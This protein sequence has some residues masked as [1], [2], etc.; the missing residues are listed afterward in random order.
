MAAYHWQTPSPGAALERV[1]AIPLE[2]GPDELLLEVLHCGLCHSDVSMID[3]AWSMSSYP[4]VPGHEAVG[5]VIAVGDG[6]DP[7][8]VGELR[9][10]GWFAGSCGHCEQCLAGR[11]NLCSKAES[12]IV[13]RPGAFASQV[14]AHQ[15]WAIPVPAGL[16]AADAGPLFCGGITVFAPLIDEAVSPT[17]RVAVIGVGGLG[18]LALQFSRAWGCEVTAITSSPAKAEEAKRLGAH[19]V[20]AS[21]DLPSQAGRFDL[22]INTVNQPLDWAAVVAAL[23]PLGRLHLLGAVLEPIPIHA[24]DLIMTRR[25]ITGSPTSSPASLRK[26]VEFCARHGILPMVEHLPMAEVNEA[27]HRLRQGDVRFRFVLDGHA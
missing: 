3:N 2:P 27:I 21:A 23:A 17:A 5:R 12:T 11:A 1:E 6:V 24:F 16:S 10:V 25:A 19:S 20:V 13:G 14:K 18:H 4:L 26:M 22:I 9:G 8:L 15:D 7:G